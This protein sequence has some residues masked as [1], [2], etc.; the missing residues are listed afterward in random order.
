M[1]ETKESTKTVNCTR[2]HCNPLQKVPTKKMC[3]PEQ[4]E[5][6]IKQL[7]DWYQIS[8]REALRKAGKLDSQYK[9]VCLGHLN[10]FFNFGAQKSSQ[11]IA[12][13][14]PPAHLA[15]LEVSESR[16]ESVVHLGQS[17]DA[18]RDVY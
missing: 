18:L 1:H 2:M 5:L 11:C 13:H 6:N 9:C 15:L 16:T 12:C 3:N 10:R 14:V 17:S 7:E 4:L 8:R